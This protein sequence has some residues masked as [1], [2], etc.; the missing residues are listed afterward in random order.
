MAWLLNLTNQELKL[1]TGSHLGVFHHINECDV[2][3]PAEVS[4]F[5]QVQAPLLD[6]SGCPLSD[7][8]R[9]QLQALLEKHQG[10]FSRGTPT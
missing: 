4:D 2:L 5:L 3:T 9:Q 7:E 6:V 8:Q 1:H 10:V